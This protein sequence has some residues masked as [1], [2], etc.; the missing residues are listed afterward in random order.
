MNKIKHGKNCDLIAQQM[1]EF[2]NCIPRSANLEWVKD[3]N[4]IKYFESERFITICE[5]LSR[6]G[7]G[8]EKEF[9]VLDV[10]YLHGLISEFT[11]REFPKARFT[12][13]DHPESPNFSNPEYLNIISA[14]PYMQLI[15]CLI[16]DAA[17]LKRKFDVI[18]L[19]EIIEHLDPTV[20]TQALQTLRELIAEDGLLIITTP[21]AVGLYN[22]YMMMTDGD[23]IVLPP[24][25]DSTMGF[26][27]IH[28]WSAPVLERTANWCGFKKDA[29]F[30]NHGREGEK[31][32]R[33][34]REWISL[35]SQVFL[36]AV[37]LIGNMK[38]SLRGFFVASFLPTKK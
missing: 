37:E 21:N 26:G 6:H 12:V 28:L 5:T 3:I 18:I 30:F 15:P 4:F 29:L 17:K 9:E 19:G 7:L 36:K 20:V 8:K 14:R 25:P 27:H 31:F 23:G 2:V 10:G 16:S 34:R 24:I 35:K 1:L 13:I 38:P 32:A 33:A 22:S 11:H